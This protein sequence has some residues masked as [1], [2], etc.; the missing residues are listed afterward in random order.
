[1]AQS[2]VPEWTYQDYIQTPDLNV[3]LLYKESCITAFNCNC[4]CKYVYEN[5]NNGN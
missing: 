4:K 3:F 2:N 1:M 5:E